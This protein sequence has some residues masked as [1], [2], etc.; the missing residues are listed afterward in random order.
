MSFSQYTDPDNDPYSEQIEDEV[1][2][3]REIFGMSLIEIAILGFLFLVILIFGGFVGLKILAN[4]GNTNS[5]AVAVAVVQP[6]HTL[7]PSSTP[8]PTQGAISTS[9]P[10][11]GWN[12]F[13]FADEM[14][15]ISLPSSYQGGDPVAYPEIAIM[16]LETYSMD[17][18]FIKYAQG[19]ISN[20]ETAF[21]AFD[22]KD[23]NITRFMY[24]HREEIPPNIDFTMDGYLN[25]GEDSLADSDIQVVDRYIRSLDY[26]PEAGVLIFEKQIPIENGVYF[27]LTF[28]SYSIRINNEVWNIIF[29]TGRD[30]FKEYGPIIDN[31]VRSFY[32]QP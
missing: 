4:F 7:I 24:V 2:Q 8:P 28:S 15:K 17:K 29:Q 30:D 11:P 20:P 10:I 5:D 14:A 26:Y 19:I 1:P 18:A 27:Y 3:K 9:T 23:T 12:Q 6:T 16:T 25:L 22:P 32:V 21:F 31:S 13:N